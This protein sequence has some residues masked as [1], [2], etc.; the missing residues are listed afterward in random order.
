MALLDAPVFAHIK[1]P[2]CTSKILFWKSKKTAI[3]FEKVKASTKVDHGLAYN[4]SLSH[5][6]YQ[7]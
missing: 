3:Q 4:Q 6:G 2:R 7:L 1:P 5:L